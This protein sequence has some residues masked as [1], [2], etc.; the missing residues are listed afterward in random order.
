MTPI[1]NLELLIQSTDITYEPDCGSWLQIGAI[2][3]VILIGPKFE[4]RT[5]AKKKDQ[6]SQFQTLGMTDCS[7]ARQLERHGRIPQ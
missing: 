6:N 7:S 2:S 3:R 1:L 4:V 5:S